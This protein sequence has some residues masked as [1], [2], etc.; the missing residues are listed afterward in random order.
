MTKI[1]SDFEGSVFLNG[2][3]YAAGDKVPDG[4]HVGA[5]LTADGKEYGAPV[6]API[7][8]GDVT[9]TAPAPDPLTPEETEQAEGIG[10]PFEDL[11]PTFVRGVLAGHA[12]GREDGVAE[13]LT[14]AAA[15]TK[16]DL[17]ANVPDVLAHIEAH[18]D[19]TAAVLALEAAGEARAGILKKY[20][21]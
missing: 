7:P 4:V 18:P 1:R 6:A 21:G 13:T 17:S 16:L 19:E 8:T 11:D 20:L 5:H 10:L 15:G 14:H 3:P 2:K 9:A 12:Q